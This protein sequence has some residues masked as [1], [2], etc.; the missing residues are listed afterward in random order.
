[1]EAGS[2]RSS[3]FFCRSFQDLWDFTG[4]SRRFP[5]R[6]CHRQMKEIILAPES[7]RAADLAGFVEET[8]EQGGVPPAVIAKMNIAADEVFSNI[9][10][11]SHATRMH[12]SAEAAGGTVYL[13]FA[14]DGVP[15]DPTGEREVD[16]SSG[17]EDREPGGLGIFL[18]RKFMDEVSYTYLGGQ[19]ILELRRTYAPAADPAWK[20]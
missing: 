19:N 11:Y 18:V 5:A 16:V 17:L 15:Y 10:R 14:D 8:L 12:V 9:C 1:M 4:C 20:Q 2:K 6:C 7:A 3:L 13:R